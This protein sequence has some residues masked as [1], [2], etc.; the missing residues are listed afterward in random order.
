ML[1]GSPLIQ[2]GPY[3]VQNLLQTLFVDGL[4]NIIERVHFESLNRELVIGRQKKNNRQII[5]IQLPYD[6]EPADA[7]HLN[8][9]CLL[10]TSDAAD[11]Q[12]RV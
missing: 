6:L 3:L 1:Q 4:E 12:W 9:H 8:I 2:V 5:G 11:D 10:Y 7:G